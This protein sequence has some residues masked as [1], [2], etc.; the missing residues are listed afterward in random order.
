MIVAINIPHGAR[1]FSAFFFAEGIKTVFHGTH[2]VKQILT[3]CSLFIMCHE[4]PLR[5]TVR[6]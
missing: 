3:H 5:Y 4:N 6:Y 2:Y 1:Q